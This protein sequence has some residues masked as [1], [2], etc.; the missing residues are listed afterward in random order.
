MFFMPVAVITA[1]GQGV[2]EYYT[3]KVV[4]AGNAPEFVAWNWVSLVLNVLIAALALVTIFV[5]KP[6]EKSVKPTLLLQLRMCFVNVVL[7]LGMVVLLWLQVR[8]VA[9]E[10]KAEWTANVSFIFPVV[11]IVFSWLAIRGIVKDI[12]LLRSYDR[13][14]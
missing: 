8:G 1:P 2:Y 10:I 5:R 9:G 4:M 7:M 14:R 12:A 11:G 13:V 6:K 3:T